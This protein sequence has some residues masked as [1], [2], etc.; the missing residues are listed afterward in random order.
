MIIYVSTANYRDYSFAPIE[1]WPTIPVEVPDDFSG[2]NKTYNPE[3]GD[4]ITD[5]PYVPTHEDHVRDAEAERQ[6]LIGEANDFINSKQWP[7]KLAL[8]RLSDA[9]KAK[10]NLWLDY[11]DA[12]DAIDSSTAPDIDWPPKPAV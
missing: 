3:T 5:P 7:A 12:L 2:G 6:R 1:G 9:D 4:W 11:I 8:G 10:Y